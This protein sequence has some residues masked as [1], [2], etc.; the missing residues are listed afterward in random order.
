[1]TA[2]TEQP[3]RLY[4]TSSLTGYNTNFKLSIIL[5]VITLSERVDKLK[6]LKRSD[7]Y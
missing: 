5:H 4:M 3:V 1:M 2:S 7:L 6:F